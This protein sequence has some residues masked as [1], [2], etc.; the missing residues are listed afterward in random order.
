MFEA[1]ITPLCWYCALRSEVPIAPPPKRVFATYVVHDKR[2]CK[3]VCD[4]HAAFRKTTSTIS[5]H[6]DC[7]NGHPDGRLPMHVPEEHV[8]RWSPK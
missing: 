3:F 8:T 4:D 5:G 7:P 6:K 2:G 1:T